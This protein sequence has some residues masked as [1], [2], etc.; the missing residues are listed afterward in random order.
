MTFLSKHKL[1]CVTCQ[2]SKHWICCQCAYHSNGEYHSLPC[3]GAAHLR[4]DHHRL[5]PSRKKVTPHTGAQLTSMCEA[6]K[7]NHT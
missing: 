2:V 1:V 6:G 7:P 3:D 5:A 4:V